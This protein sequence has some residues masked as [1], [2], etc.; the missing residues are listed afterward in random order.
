MYLYMYMCICIYIYIYIY[1]YYITILLDYSIVYYIGE[2]SA[3]DG[4]GTPDPNPR[5]SVNS[6]PSVLKYFSII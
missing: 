5:N 4:I 1:K 6:R 3:A 2:P